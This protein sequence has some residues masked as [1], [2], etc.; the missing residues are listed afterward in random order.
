LAIVID[1]GPL[2]A[3]YDRS[4]RDHLAC[5]RLIENADE[6][7]VI[8][9]PVVPEFDWLA[10]KRG[11]TPITLALFADI[12][13][14]GY[15]LFDLE[16]ADYARAGDIMRQYADFPIGFV[17]AAV[18]AVVERLGEPKLATLDRRHFG[19][20]KPRHVLNLQLLPE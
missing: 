1:T 13:D 7:I 19:A 5:K 6:R 2:F 11:G 15:D 9:A 16:L 3:A 14:G 18:L 12:L 8:P 10:V 17:D 4:D 20:M